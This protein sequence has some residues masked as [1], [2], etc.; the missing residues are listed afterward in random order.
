YEYLQHPD[1]AQT[2][3]KALERLVAQTKGSPTQAMPL[4]TLAE[5]HYQ[6]GNGYQAPADGMPPTSEGASDLRWAFK[7]SF[8]ILRQIVDEFPDSYEAEAAKSLIGTIKQTSLSSCVESVL[9][10]QAAGLV[11][12]SY[13]NIPE[14][15]L[16]LVQISEEEYLFAQGQ[17]DWLRRLVAKPSVQQWS[18][19]LPDAGDFRMHRTETSFRGLARG[20]YCLLLSTDSKFP[21]VQSLTSHAPFW[22]SELGV[23]GQQDYTSSNEY[24]VV[25]RRSGQPVAHAQVELWHKT[26]RRDQRKSTIATYYTDTLGQIQNVE[27][28]RRQVFVGVATDTDRLYSLDG[29]YL[30]SYPRESTQEELRMH[31]FLDRAIYRPGQTL[32]FKGLLLQGEQGA[33]PAI[34]TGQAVTITLYDANGQEVDQLPLTTNAWGSLRGEFTLPATG[35][36]GSMRLGSEYGNVSFRVEAYK[37][38]RFQVQ[39]NELAQA[40][41]L[42]DTVVISGKAIAYAGPAIADAKVTYS[43]RRRTFYPWFY[44]RYPTPDE[45]VTLASGSLRSDDQGQF[46]F[47]FPALAGPHRQAA[48]YYQFEIQVEVTDDAGETRTSSKFLRLAEF[49]VRLSITAP[50]QQDRAT[51]LILELSSKN[52]D[53]QDVSCASTLRIKHLA[54][55]DQVQVERYWPLPDTLIIP[56]GA[57]RRDFPHLAYRTSQATN[58]AAGK[59]VY[60]APLKLRGSTTLQLDPKDWP[61]GQYVLELSTVSPQGDTL[62]QGHKLTLN[63][64]AAAEFSRDQALH[65]L[66]PE[67]TCQPGETLRLRLG[68]GAADI[69]VYVENQGQS[70]KLNRAWYQ[71]K[72]ITLLSYPISEA[73]RGTLVY[74]LHYFYQ[75]RHAQ[76][77]LRFRIPWQNKKLQIRTESF[78]KKLSPGMPERWMLRI[79][80]PDSSAATA[81][82]LASM[83]D[84][85]LDQFVAHQWRFSP[86]PRFPRTRYWRSKAFDYQNLSLW[87]RHG[88]FDSYVATKD[89]PKLYEVRLGFGHRS[90]IVYSTAPDEGIEIR[91]SVR[92]KAQASAGMAKMESPEEDVAPASPVTEAATQQVPPPPLRKNLQETAFFLPDLKTDSDGSLTLNFTSPEALTAWKFQVF[93][94]DQSLA[95]ALHSKE[96]VTQKELMILPNFPRF[97]RTGDQIRLAAKVSNLSGQAL[98][99]TA[100]L[101]LFNLVSGQTLNHCLSGLATY[102]LDLAADESQAAYWQLQV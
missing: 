72:P 18:V 13:R 63:D 36:L 31:Y 54:G 33:Y 6:R 57:F 86:E 93:S 32:Y 56:A 84:A 48:P 43:V 45:T 47:E 88:G 35:L 4:L 8:H 10:P 25:N 34:A 20:V 3:Q 9:L 79:L 87:L 14:I 15:H 82:V 17:D 75:N 101:E 24:M 95:Y 71:P 81:E 41:Q 64:W 76:Q 7:T 16:R 60:E 40:A 59:L 91:T 85:S 46:S 30:R 11:S 65:I 61:I 66:A 73:D 26:G 80:N 52:Y 27:G 96:I 74:Q 78:R 39:L 50:K 90:P 2:Y 68:S 98:S 77:E 58:S 28:G 62:V 55:P 21:T 22:V 5:W 19:Q 38:P 51:P 53:D 44:W 100:T 69:G 29:D 94:Q 89:Y 97:V 1:K 49:P 102:E 67:D 12:I 42:G 23:L 99:A 37:R 92:D 70:G 83:Y